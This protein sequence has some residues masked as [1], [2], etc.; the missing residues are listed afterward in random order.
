M[1][2]LLPFNSA[3]R[4]EVSDAARELKIRTFA[5]TIVRVN[6]LADDREKYPMPVCCSY[7]QKR[8]GSTGKSRIGAMALAQA[9]S[10]KKYK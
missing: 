2:T 5:R 9:F 6:V 7:G 3:T 10:F 1:V 8:F 4:D